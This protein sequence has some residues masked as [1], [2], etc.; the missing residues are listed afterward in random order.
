[1]GRYTLNASNRIEAIWMAKDHIRMEARCESIIG[2]T[3]DKYNS[4]RCGYTI[5]KVVDA[6]GR[7]VEGYWVSD[8][9]TRLEVNTPSGSRNIWIIENMMEGKDDEIRKLR[10]Q[11]EELTAKLDAIKKV[12]G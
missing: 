1:M 2:L 9:N 8:L 4:D 11:V 5:F 10:E 12:I 7:D 3:K 6:E